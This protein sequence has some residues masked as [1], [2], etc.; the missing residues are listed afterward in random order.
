MIIR[1]LVRTLVEVLSPH[2]DNTSIHQHYKL[3]EYKNQ[4][5]RI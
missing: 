4:E 5:N 2:T 3:K 1:N